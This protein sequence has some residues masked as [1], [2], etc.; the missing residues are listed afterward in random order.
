M[1]IKALNL[2][3]LRN[4]EHYKFQS[5]FKELIELETAETLGVSALFADYLPIYAKEMEAL[6]IVMKSEKTD[7][8]ANADLERGLTGKGLRGTVKGA[9]NHYKADVRKASAKIELVLDSYGDLASRNYNAQTAAI[10]KLVYE[11][12]MN[13][14]N[15]VATLG[16]GEWLAALKAQNDAFEAIM[17]A[18]YTDESLKT[19][20]R[21]KVVRAEVDKSYRAI[22][23]RINALIEVNGES[24]YTYFVDQINV[25]ID[26]YEHILSRRK[27]RNAKANAAEE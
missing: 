13:Y 23:K 10:S 1:E 2:N 22:V 20:Y 21:M 15:E 25:R 17:N 18:R 6:Y 27:G 16:I 24:G 5:D 12:T 7:M 14:A 19:P 26:N 11:L 3:N 4:A 9:L 8:L